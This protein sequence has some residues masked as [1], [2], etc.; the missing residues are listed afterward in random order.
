MGCEYG[1]PQVM[2]VTAEEPEMELPGFSEAQIDTIRS[3][4]PLISNNGS[5]VTA[6]IFIRIFSES[7]SV[8]DLFRHFQVYS[9]EDFYHSKLFREHA[10]RFMGVIQ[11]LVDNLETPQN[12][13]QQLLL[14][15]AKHATF[16]GYHPDYFRSYSKCMMDVW[17]VELGEEFIHEV[18]DSWRMAF[19]YVVDRMTEGF[20]MCLGGQFQDDADDCSVADSPV[21][22]NK[23]A[24]LEGGGGGGGGRGGG[25]PPPRVVVKE[26]NS[27][28][29]DSTR[30][31]QVEDGG[32]ETTVGRLTL[33][34]DNL[35]RVQ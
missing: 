35:V 19:D 31:Q 29:P 32:A 15:G 11:D 10:G 4:W 17:E 34:D 1:K 12:V 33:I 23:S 30:K 18:R 22:I 13:D 8:H 5:R 26:M 9:S 16:N 21:K 3:T 14:L 27:S 25:G 6:E 20:D 7:P 24:P 28:L 2:T